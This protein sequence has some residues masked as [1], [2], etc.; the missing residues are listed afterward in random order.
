MAGIPDIVIKNGLVYDGTGGT[1][2]VASIGITGERVAVI[3]PALPDGNRTIDAKGL[4]VCPGFIDTHGHSE[5]TILRAPSCESKIL[6]GITTEI[7]GNC[8]LSAAPLL[9]DAASRREQDLKELEICE[10][11]SSFR[12]YFSL[13]QQR[14]IGINFASLTGHGNIRASV[15][16]YRAGDAGEIE[17][18]EMVTLVRRSMDEG[19][20]G[21]S[22]GL[23]YPPGIFTRTDEIIRLLADAGRGDKIVY[24]THMRSEGD[25]LIESIEEALRIGGEGGAKIHISH[26]K[27]SGRDN[28]YKIDEALTLVDQGVS[29]GLAISFDRYPYTASSTDLDSLLPAWVYEGGADAECRRLTNRETRAS[30]IDYLRFRYPD[31]SHY[32]SVVVSSVAT[33]RNR[34]AEGKSI[35]EVAASCGVSPE[36]AILDLILQEGT[37]VGAIFHSM[38]EDNLRRFLAHPL[39]MVGSDSAVRNFSGITAQGKPHPRAFG[40]FPRYLGKYVIGEGLIPLQEGI[41]RITSL[42]AS[43]FELTS[44]G[45]LR[46]GFFADLVVFDPSDICDRAT[47]GDPF[48]QPA[49]IR[50]VVVNGA[51]A[52]SEGEL[53]REATTGM[54]LQRTAQG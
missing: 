52:V 14:D 37:R 40:T 10:R 7:S 36:D 25:G 1:P 17:I 3:A 43:V 51:V 39:C 53:T 50:Y 4:C 33:E 46:E 5:F 26:L 45:L 48:K 15:M 24:A 34:W 6:Q 30:I 44:R 18:A 32:A 42:P 9:G 21:L 22:S 29:R 2:V 11:W 28:W 16:G 27:T 47:F 19:A 54:I 23:I 41:R 49:G 31:A 35:L 13:L 8:G 12:E 20:R 38:S